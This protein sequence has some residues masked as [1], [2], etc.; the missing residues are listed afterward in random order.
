MTRVTLYEHLSLREN[1]VKFSKFEYLLY[2][3]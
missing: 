3:Y 2:K 1:C